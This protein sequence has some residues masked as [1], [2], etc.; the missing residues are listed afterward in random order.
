MRAIIDGDTD[1]YTKMMDKLGIVLK[2]GDR[3][4]TG[5]ALM[6]RAMCTW[7]DVADALLG[8][9]VTKLPSPRAAQKYRVANLYEGPM[10]DEAATAIRSCDK[11]GPLMMYVSKMVPTSDKGR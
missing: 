11:D 4:L 5:K 3:S 1:K 10:D 7:I 6:R 8:M 2:A 9:I